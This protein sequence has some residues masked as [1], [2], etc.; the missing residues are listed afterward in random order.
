MTLNSSLLAPPYNIVI[1][2]DYFSNRY[3]SRRDFKFDDIGHALLT[4]FEVLTL[5]GW[6]DVRDIFG[7]LDDNKFDLV[8]RH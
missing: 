1:I 2:Y 5:E 3:E 4:L 8:C 6:L 7:G